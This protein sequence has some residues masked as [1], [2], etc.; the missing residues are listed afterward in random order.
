MGSNTIHLELLINI[1]SNKLK[2]ST[3]MLN[4]AYLSKKIKIIRYSIK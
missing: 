2:Q 1:I 4:L 3:S